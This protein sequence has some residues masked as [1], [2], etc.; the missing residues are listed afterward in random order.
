MPTSAAKPEHRAVRVLELG[1]VTLWVT[2]LDRSAVFYG[3]LLG[4]REIDRGILKGRRIALFSLGVHYHDLA[5]VEV[6]GTAVER[7]SRPSGLNHIGLKI[8]D[9]IEDLRQM[10]DWLLA[11]GAIP[12]LYIDHGNSKSLHVQ[13]PDGNA[14]ELYVD[15]AP[16]VHTPQGMIYSEPL[17]LD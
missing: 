4:F 3:A 1:H 8:G 6:G 16:S 10:R 15:T 11:H 12:R 9:Q 13:D 7:D 2:N 14:I 5:L 17:H